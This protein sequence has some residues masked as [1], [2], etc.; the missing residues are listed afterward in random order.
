MIGGAA[1]TICLTGLYFVGYA[2]PAYMPSSPGI[3]AALRATLATWN[4]SFGLHMA[5]SWWP[6]LGWSV[7][8]LAIITLGALVWLWLKRP[9]DRVR[10]LG[11]FLLLG[12]HIILVLG[13]GWARAPYNVDLSFPPRYGLILAPALFC[14][15]FVWEMRPFT[16]LQGVVPLALF[17]LA[18]MSIFPN[19]E[20]GLGFGRGRLATMH[21][22]ERDLRFGA[23]P[24]VL[25]QKYHDFFHHDPGGDRPTTSNC[26]TRPKSHF[27]AIRTTRSVGS[28]PW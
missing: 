13:V 2:R 10:I 9:D 18:W 5:L 7:L 23:S 1:V 22:F 28:R 12:A 25:A 27:S 11:L 16:A 20:T 4:T 24:A 3:G 14:I 26:C 21:D 17:L 6:Y 8:A 15:Y 19:T